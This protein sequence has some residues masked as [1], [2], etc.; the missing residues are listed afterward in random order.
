MLVEKEN[1]KIFGEGKF[2]LCVAKKQRRQR[3]KIFDLQRRR[4]MEKEEFIW[5]RKINGDANVYMLG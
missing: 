2:P 4:T 3:R 1:K 5:R